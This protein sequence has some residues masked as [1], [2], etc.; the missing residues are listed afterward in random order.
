MNTPKP[1]ILFVNDYDFNLEQLQP[2]LRDSYDLHVIKDQSKATAAAQEIKPDVILLDAFLD[3]EKEAY[4]TMREL[5]ANENLKNTPVIFVGEYFDLAAQVRGYQAGAKDFIGEFSNAAVIRLKID[6][7][8]T[9]VQL[10]KQ[11][12][13]KLAAME[14]LVVTDYLTQLPNKRAFDE[15]LALEWSKAARA[16]SE[17]AISSPPSIRSQKSTLHAGAISLLSIDI[18]KFKVYNDTYGHPQGDVALKSVANVLR[19]IAAR[20]GDMASRWG[21]EEFFIILPS[22]ELR[23]AEAIAERIRKAVEDLVIYTKDEAPTKVT[24][25]IGLHTH[26]PTKDCSIAQAV[27]NADDALYQAKASGRNKTVV[28]CPK[29]TPS[30]ASETRHN[31]RNLGGS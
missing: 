19:Q 9:I 14:H 10:Q 17:N 29:H 11:L 18:D 31:L 24:V 23:G 25:S 5:Q 26:Y 21:G 4:A 3:C 30:I 16:N 15:R 28:S 6:T 20:P 7:Q 22:T 13:E 1:K 12:Q 2:V 27:K 8:V